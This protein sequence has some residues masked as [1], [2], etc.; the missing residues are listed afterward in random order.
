M[1]SPLP[2]RQKTGKKTWTLPIFFAPRSELEQFELLEAS[3]RRS[4]SAQG[5][6][7]GTGKDGRDAVCERVVAEWCDPEEPFGG[8]HHAAGQNGHFESVTEIGRHKVARRQN[9]RHEVLEPL[10]GEHADVLE[11]V[12]LS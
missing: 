5:A 10:V 2:G 4:G 7:G 9:Q 12:G 3:V 8:F 11:V 6:A 1:I